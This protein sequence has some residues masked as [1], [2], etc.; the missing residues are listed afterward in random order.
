MMMM[1][2]CLVFQTMMHPNGT[3]DDAN[4]EMAALGSAC[5]V[6]VSQSPLFH[7][8]GLMLS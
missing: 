3:D 1:M 8:C 7:C 5:P 2:L 6:L 4:V